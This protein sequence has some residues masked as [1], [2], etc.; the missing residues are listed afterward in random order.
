MKKVVIGIVIFF[1]FSNVNAQ[2]TWTQVGKSIIGEAEEDQSGASISLSSDGSIVAIGAPYNCGSGY[3][4]GQVRIFRNESGGWEKIGSDIDGETGSHESGWAIS[5]SADGSTIAIGAKYSNQVRI[6]RNNNDSWIQVGNSLYGDFGD[7]QFGISVSLSADG[8]ILAVGAPYNSGNGTSSGCVYIYRYTEG[9]WSRIGKILG[10]KSYCRIGSQINLSSDGSILSIGALGNS[11]MG[12]MVS[13]YVT[14][15][16]NKDGIWQIYGNDPNNG[17]IGQ[18]TCSYKNSLSSDGSTIAIA[19][20][21][22]YIQYMHIYKIIDG[23]WTQV[24]SEIQ[25]EWDS[26]SEISFALNADGSRIAI[27]WP[28]YNGN[29]KNTGRVRIFQNSLNSWSQIGQDIYGNYVGESSGNSVSLNANGSIVGIG[30]S[31]NA[32]NGSFSG[33]ARVFTNITTELSSLKEDSYLVSPNPTNGLLKINADK[34]SIKAILLTDITGKTIYKISGSQIGS[35]NQ[36]DISYFAKGIYIL[37]IQKDNEEFTTK[38]VK[39]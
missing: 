19:D 36:I 35:T 34:S 15:Y 20:D 37:N 5:L 30:V 2:T 28:I 4:T 24:G 18:F 39:K 23:S 6:F 32:E 14:I 33:A 7:D 10:D 1:L 13:S 3:E 21:R 8:N 11:E 26:S 12:K 27:G 38:I 22:N 16:Q 9:N 31:G 29:G 25:E 17:S